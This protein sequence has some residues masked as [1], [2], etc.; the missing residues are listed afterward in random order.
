MSEKIN[1]RNFAFQS[2]A[3][4]LS[5]LTLSHSSSGDASLAKSQ[6]KPT[7]DLLSD[8]FLARMPELTEQTG[9]PGL[10]IAI[11]K[12][13]KLEW[14]REFG[15]K[16]SMTKVPVDAKTLFQAASLSKPVF[17]Y[18][19][20]KMREEKLIDIDQPLHSYLPLPDLEGHDRARKI[21]ARHVMSHTTGLQN[22]RISRENKLTVSFAPGE[23]FGYSG[24]GF[25]HL[26][27]VI[28][29]I[30][31]R[32]IDQL[33]RERIFKPFGMETSSYSWLADHASLIS[34]GHNFRG[35][36]SDGWS[37]RQGPK[38]LELATKANKPLQSW[39]YEDVLQAFPEI[40]SS[41]PP[42]P[43]FMIPNVAGSLLTTATEYAR[44]LV[45][46]MDSGSKD[47]FSISEATRREMLTPQISINSALA[48]GLGWGLESAGGRN[49]FWHWGDNG[50]FKAFTIN[51]LSRRWGI[52][53]LANSS[54]GLKLCN[55]IVREATGHDHP[56]FLWGMVS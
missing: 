39:K 1:R 41:L 25:F 54:G 50:I 8:S 2:G 30:A 22:W 47:E 11:V 44:F 33:M 19:V 51:D 20:L 32:G 21:T 52:V 10:A 7:S 40:N 18:L 49:Y 13:G 4:L 56:A 15:V 34:S 42:L 36:P 9:V 55:P 38:M 5:A 17:T 27:R 16:N 28:E 45:R 12:D 35:E 14:T 53:I 48:W 6:S 31:D 3:T 46:L 37:A 24:E 43:N 23:R 26:Q 29:K